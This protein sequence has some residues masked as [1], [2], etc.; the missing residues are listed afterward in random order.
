MDYKTFFRDYGS[1]NV[2]EFSKLNKGITVEDLYQIFKSRIKDELRIY[3]YDSRKIK[4]AN[5]LS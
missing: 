3:M 4:Q 1:C 5:K 2:L